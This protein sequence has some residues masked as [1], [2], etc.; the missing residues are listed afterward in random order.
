MASRERGK[1]EI[2]P[3]QKSLY[4][5]CSFFQ[6][7]DTKALVWIIIA[8]LW[9]ILDVASFIGVGIVLEL[10]KSF[11]IILAIFIRLIILLL[12]GYFIFVVLA[13]RQELDQSQKIIY[14]NKIFLPIGVLSMF[15][16]LLD[17]ALLDKINLT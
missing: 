11:T 6:R 16:A 1:Y 2:C 7:N 12:D 13:F 3:I 4:K 17:Y 9:Y 15:L 5:N 10:P 14:G 8:G